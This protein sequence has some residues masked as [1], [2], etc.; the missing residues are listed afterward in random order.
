MSLKD[1]FLQHTQDQH[2]KE[3]AECRICPRNCGVN[4]L[5]GKTGTCVSDAGY[6]ISSICIHRGEEP[7]ISGKNGICNIFFS[8]CNLSCI[9]CQ[10]WQ[11][12]CSMGDLPK[13]SMR[14]NE[15]L[16]EICRNLDKGCHAVGFVSPS[17]VIPHVKTIIDALRLM[18][19]NPVFVYNS[20]GYDNAD[21]LK[22]L[23][24]Y[25][26]V[27]LPDFKYANRKIAR[28]FSSA[29]NYP[30]KALLAV[31]EMYR[32]KG[33]TLRLDEEG[34]AENGLIIRHLIL[35]G[36][37]QNSLDVLR[38]LAYELSESVSLSLMA[39][40]WPTPAV[41]QHASLGRTLTRKEYDVVVK[42]MDRLGFY[43]G[44]VQ[45]LESHST[46][47]PDFGEEHPFEK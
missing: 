43:K 7:A 33:S 15:V 12:S 13:K 4:R 23:E 31:R 1:T 40:Y 11:I 38:L 47:R 2:F 17:H 44:W 39:Q 29:A 6:P 36:N 18:G 34:E 14:L 9:Y 37:V 3:L 19:R 24:S 42:E 10:N 27:Y 26:D 35:P 30:E 28:E 21:Q 5:E 8:N 16:I 41:S 25:I 22:S 20:N 32:Q 45:A 46:Y